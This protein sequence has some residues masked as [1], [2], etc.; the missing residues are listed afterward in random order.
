MKVVFVYAN[1]G[2]GHLRVT[3]ALIASMPA[4]FEASVLASTEESI[5]FF[6]RFMSTNWLFRAFG[7]WVQKGLP[8]RIFAKVYPKILSLNSRKIAIKLAK[9]REKE[10]LV[11][12][13]HFG[14]AHQ[15]GSV[16]KYL[17]SKFGINI[18]LVV[19]VTDDS[20]QFIWYVPEAD[21]IFVPSHKT[22]LALEN[23]SRG[24]LSPKIIVNTYPL[25]P[26]L[27]RVLGSKETVNRVE[28]LS[29]DTDITTNIIMPISGAAVGLEFD[30]SL[31]KFLSNFKFNYDFCIVSREANFTK[32]FLKSVSELPNVGVFQAKNL[33][34]VVELYDLAYSM[35]VF[36]LEITKPS[37]QVFKALLPPNEQGG[38]ILLLTKPVGRQEYDNLDFLR[39]HGLAPTK[40]ENDILIKSALNNKN[41]A[42]VEK[43]YKVIPSC[44]RAISLPTDAR[45]AAV[46]VN[47]AKDEGLFIKMFSCRADG[48][49]NDRHKDELGDLGSKTFWNELDVL[50]VPLYNVT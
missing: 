37:E 1:A 25:S 30:L 38:V 11:V 29:S 34:R 33:D 23:Y 24:K 13:T 50:P 19:C 45:K 42:W 31:V 18:K 26:H 4:K 15:I 39:R 3:K 35:R 47:W 49:K 22:K 12:A 44:W 2:L 36:S 7:E 20:P 43:E 10:L 14:L 5:T 21:F 9:F 17:A 41:L 32:N 48:K 28:Q 16:K 40:F 8:E 46:F 27:A 6:H